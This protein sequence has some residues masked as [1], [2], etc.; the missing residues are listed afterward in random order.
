MFNFPIQKTAITAAFERITADGCIDFG[1][2]DE[3][4]QKQIIKRVLDDYNSAEILKRLNA[5]LNHPG[6]VSQKER[7]IDENKQAILKH[8][9]EESYAKRLMEIYKTISRRPVPQQ[10]DKTVLLAEFLEL[11]NFS[12]LK[13]CDYLE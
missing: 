5:Y 1:L 11:D 3:G 10:I 8:Y 7:L 12:L 13:W 9:D 6:D 2:L 4:F